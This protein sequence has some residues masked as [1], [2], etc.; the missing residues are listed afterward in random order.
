MSLFVKRYKLKNT[1]KGLV[2]FRSN[3]PFKKDHKKEVD[4]ITCYKCS[5]L[6]HYRTTCSNLTKHHK[7]KD[8][9]FYKTKRKSS[10]GLRAYIT[11]E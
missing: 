6:G 2:N 4:G 8:K 11:W 3:H 1:Y 7:S 10:K 9:A 5:K